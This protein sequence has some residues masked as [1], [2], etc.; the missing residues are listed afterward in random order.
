MIT[1]SHILAL[2]SFIGGYVDF[3]NHFF[4][5]NIEQEI[6]E[7]ESDLLLPFL[8]FG[9]ITIDII[10]K[11]IELDCKS[12]T[13][14][15]LT[16]NNFNFNERDVILAIKHDNEHVV[17]YIIHHNENIIPIEKSVLWTIEKASIYILH[18]LFD[19]LNICVTPQM[20]NVCI[21]RGHHEMFEF[22]IKKC[23]SIPNAALISCSAYGREHMIKFLLENK[24][25][26]T[27]GQSL[28]N[29]CQYGDSEIV[30]LLLDHNSYDNY[31][32]NIALLYSISNNYCEVVKLLLEK[33]A[34]DEFSIIY[35]S[36]YGYLE[37]IKIL[38]NSLIINH[39]TYLECVSTAS[40]YGHLEISEYLTDIDLTYMNLTGIN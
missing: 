23:N 22:L 7:S 10:R 19:K 39:E 3:C 8:H 15:L 13:K 11:T 38:F 6:T 34:N 21:K 17:E 32:L 5:T 9:D 2:D 30:K 33:G 37:M 16:K 31:H 27:N 29:A 35:A 36:K 4:E 12:S 1:D 18:L 20:F 25:R 14:W 28:C 26:D 24:I 40:L